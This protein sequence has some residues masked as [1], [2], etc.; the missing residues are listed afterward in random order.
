MVLPFLEGQ[1]VGVGAGNK[2]RK[3]FVRRLRRKSN[4]IKRKHKKA[5]KL[6]A[7][8]TRK[9]KRHGLKYPKILNLDIKKVRYDSPRLGRS[10]YI[11]TG[12]QGPVFIQAS[13]ASAYVKNLSVLGSSVRKYQGHLRFMAHVLTQEA[14]PRILRRIL[15][16]YRFLEKKRPHGFF[17]A[18]QGCSNSVWN[19]R[20]RSEA[21]IH[22]GFMA[23][24]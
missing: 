14:C 3:T 5:V 6:D 16:L 11:N 10:H 4:L 12:P 13:Y 21:N 19:M 8:F 7:V 18:L 2:S 17:R 23:G 20:S 9:L 24:K 15:R 22:L 1:E